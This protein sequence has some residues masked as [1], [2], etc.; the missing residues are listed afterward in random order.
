MNEPITFSAPFKFYIVRNQEG[1]FFRA[2]G[3]NGYGDTW[4]ADPTLAK[5]YQKIGQARSRVTFFA[6]NYPEYGVPEILEM[7]AHSAVVLDETKRVKK[8]LQKIHDDKVAG[9]QRHLD[10]QKA[11]LDRKQAELDRQRADLNKRRK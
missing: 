3:F 9:V 2:K 1:K 10:R 11:E 4:T 8:A 5:V 6:N 7:T